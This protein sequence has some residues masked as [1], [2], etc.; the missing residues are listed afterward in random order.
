MPKPIKKQK[1]EA[2]AKVLA[3]EGKHI[4][5]LSLSR[6]K[7]KKAEGLL[8]ELIRIVDSADK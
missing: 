4:A 7:A 8:N 1:P 2:V 5:L 6:P 3:R